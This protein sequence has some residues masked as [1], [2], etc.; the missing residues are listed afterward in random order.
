MAKPKHTKPIRFAGINNI[1]D[2][3]SGQTLLIALADDGRVFRGTIV[4][5]E[6]LHFHWDELLPVNQN[7][8]CEGAVNPMAKQKT[9]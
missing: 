2:P 3:T 6:P 7:C 4:I 1:Q 8:N 9:S 5:A